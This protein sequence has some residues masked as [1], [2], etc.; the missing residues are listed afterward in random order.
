MFEMHNSV[1]LLHGTKSDHLP[2][3][4]G[5]HE[6]EDKTDERD[7]ESESAAASSKPKPPQGV[8]HIFQ[9]MKSSLKNLSPNQRNKRQKQ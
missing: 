1:L 4:G 7:D 6:R 5:L 9:K 3:V 8:Y 2:D